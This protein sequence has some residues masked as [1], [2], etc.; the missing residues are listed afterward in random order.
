MLL[1]RRRLLQ[2]ADGFCVKQQKDKIC[3]LHCWNI[4]PPTNSL[5]SW[6]LRQRYKYARNEVHAYEK[7]KT[8][9]NSPALSIRWVREENAGD[10]STL[11]IRR[12][13]F[14]ATS[15]VALTLLP[16]LPSHQ[17]VTDNFSSFNN[18]ASGKSIL[19]KF[20]SA[21]WYNSLQFV[22]KTVVNRINAKNAF[23]N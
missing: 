20:I 22:I 12:I 23:L 11:S 10:T 16:L 6:I 21:D 4:S 13:S 3:I 18:S 19:F 14:G 2:F 8:K 15:L 5:W 9:M 1:N 7:R 17:E